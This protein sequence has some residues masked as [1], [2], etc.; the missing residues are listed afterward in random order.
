MIFKAL[1]SVV[2]LVF[3]GLL[4]VA[5]S[6]SAKP[7]RALKEVTQKYR[8][9]KMVEM[10]VDK[11]IKS[12]LLGREVTYNGKIFLANGKFRWENKTPDETLLV[13][14]GT[15]IWSVQMPPKEFGGAVQILKGK[16]DKKTR[17]QIL[18]STLLGKEPIERNFK[19]LKEEKK[20]NLAIL[21][22]APQ[23]TDLT[24]KKLNLVLDTK[25]KEM[26]EVSYVD[27][28]GNLTTLKFSNIQF[29]KKEDKN[30]FKYVP[31]KGAQVSNL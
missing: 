12:E 23:G 31:P 7:S 18:I 28:V 3:V 14:D 27:D 13:F 30:L 4:F 17:S 8:N 5:I 26:S 1:K 10:A 22:V 25:K 19:V 29:L 9:A 11:V 16:V 24:I 20:D 2:N 21:E 15:T 6:V